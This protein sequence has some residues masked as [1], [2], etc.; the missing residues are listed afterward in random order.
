MAKKRKLKYAK[1]KSEGRREKNKRQKMQKRIKNIKPE[2]QKII[3]DINEI[4]KLGKLGASR[5]MTSYN[6]DKKDLRKKGINTGSLK[7][8]RVKELEKNNAMNKI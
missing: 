1:Y 5:K 8:N 3:K 6:K 4:G 2:T 7:D